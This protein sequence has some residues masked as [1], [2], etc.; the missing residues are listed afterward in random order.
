MKGHVLKG[1]SKGRISLVKDVIEDQV[2]RHCLQNSKLPI[3]RVEF[4]GSTYEGLQTEAAEKVSV[5]VILKTTKS[6]L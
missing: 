4:T 1:I 6:W 3:R 5:M 2:M